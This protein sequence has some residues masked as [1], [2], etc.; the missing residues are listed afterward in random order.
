MLDVMGDALF[1]TMI[2]VL[3]N[4]GKLC[5]SGSIGGQKTEVDL[6]R[7]YLKH[8]TLYGS[9]L[10]TREE[11]RRMLQ[12]I[13]SGQVRPVIDRVF[14]LEEAAKAQKYFKEGGKMGKIL[15]RP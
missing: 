8:I 6:R 14:P 11:Y 5:I 4:G 1:Q 9:V 13:S 12:T 10:G 7:V 15:L 2:A 3:K